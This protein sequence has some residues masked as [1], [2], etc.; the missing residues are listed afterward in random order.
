MVNYITCKLSS[1]LMALEKKEY[2]RYLQTATN[3]YQSVKANIEEKG[4]C[5]Q[6]SF[7]NV[8]DK[9]SVKR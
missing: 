1:K 9:Y 6:I 8:E 5:K 3:K 7:R 4:K 2:K